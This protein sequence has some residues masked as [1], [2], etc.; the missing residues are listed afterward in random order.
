MLKKRHRKPIYTLKIKHSRTI[1]CSENNI[2]VCTC[3]VLYVIIVFNNKKRVNVAILNKI[4][5]SNVIIPILR[6]PNNMTA[7]IE[8]QITLQRISIE[9]VLFFSGYKMKEINT[10]IYTFLLYSMY[11]H[12]FHVN[13][14]SYF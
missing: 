12:N 8:S 5:R 13:F 4:T 9:E 2:N 11:S 6:T 14:F 3:F 10:K 7:G 1:N